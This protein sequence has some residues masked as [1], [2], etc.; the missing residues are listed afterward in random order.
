MAIIVPQLIEK[1]RTQL[2]ELTGL[3]IG[4]TLAI[5]KDERGWRVSVEMV[6]K[7]SIPDSMDILA[8][9]DIWLDEDGNVLEFNRKRLRKRIDTEEVEE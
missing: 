1:A 3:E 4:S 8:N 7:H 5:S 9:Y 2:S 6:E